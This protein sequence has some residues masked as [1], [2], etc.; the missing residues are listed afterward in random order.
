MGVK[1]GQANRKECEKMKRLTR[2]EAIRAKCL[3]CCCGQ[4]KEVRL[5]PRTKCALYRYRMG[6]ETA[7]EYKDA[8]EAGNVEKTGLRSPNLDKEAYCEQ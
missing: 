3:D 8:A 4:A 5:C 7:P 2:Q 1:N 6:R